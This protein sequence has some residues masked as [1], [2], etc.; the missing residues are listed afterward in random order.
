LEIKGEFGP[1]F[2]SLSLQFFSGADRGE[3]ASA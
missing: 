3:K 2:Q 1:H